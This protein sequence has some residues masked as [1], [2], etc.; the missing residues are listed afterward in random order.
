M[1]DLPSCLQIMTAKQY[2]P[3]VSLSTQLH[4]VTGRKLWSIN[5]FIGE[6]SRESTSSTIWCK[7]E[8]SVVIRLRLR[9]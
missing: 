2:H 3:V 8:N 9:S 7:Q 4:P 6:H 5:S 1:Q